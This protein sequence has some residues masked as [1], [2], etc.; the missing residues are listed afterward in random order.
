MSILCISVLKKITSHTIKKLL[1]QALCAVF[2]E[3]QCLSLY[4]GL[5]LRAA[6]NVLV[7]SFAVR[8]TGFIC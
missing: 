8:L 1:A 3:K 4:V 2:S 7:K 5:V 6:V